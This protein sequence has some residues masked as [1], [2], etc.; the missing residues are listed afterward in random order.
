V[1]KDCLVSLEKRL[2]STV[3][4]SVPGKRKKRNPPVTIR[5]MGDCSTSIQIVKVSSL[6]TKERGGDGLE[7][8]HLF[9]LKMKLLAG[10]PTRK[11][12]TEMRG[13]VERG[14]VNPKKKKNFHQL[15]FTKIGRRTA[16]ERLGL[17]CEGGNKEKNCRRRREKRTARGPDL[18]DCL[19]PGGRR[20]GEGE[21]GNL[22]EIRRYEI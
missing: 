10:G 1:K 14:G 8:S 20:K 4:V 13:F 5:G 11:E 15:A 21:G 12:G 16:L 19:S 6:E 22:V 9:Q 2:I 18:S 17:N 7:R 3:F